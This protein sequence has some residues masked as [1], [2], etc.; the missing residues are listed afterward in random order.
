MIIG[1]VPRFI[2]SVGERT[3]KIT[4]TVAWESFGIPQE[5]R[6]TQ[7]FVLLQRDREALEVAIPVAMPTLGS[8]D[9]TG[10]GN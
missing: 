3:R 6:V 9:I 7:Y 5:L 8:G 2:N 1:Q 4:L 10:V